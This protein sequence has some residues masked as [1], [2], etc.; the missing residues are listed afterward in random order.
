MPKQFNTTCISVRLQ[1][2]SPGL[3]R[4]EFYQ[5][6]YETTQEKAGGFYDTNPVSLLGI[7]HF[8]VSALS[9]NH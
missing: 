1:G 3:I 2:I 6:K 5:C 7:T 9:P 4:T 8:N